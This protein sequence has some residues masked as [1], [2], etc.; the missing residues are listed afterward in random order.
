MAL[1]GLLTAGVIGVWK[2][3]APPGLLFLAGIPGL[4]VGA[5]S[6]SIRSVI[7]AAVVSLAAASTLSA[8][9]PPGAATRRIRHLPGRRRRRRGLRPGP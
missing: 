9:A 6:A 8:S 1:T 2:A 7:C 5:S 3:S 4:L